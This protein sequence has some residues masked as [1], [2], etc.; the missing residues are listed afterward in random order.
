MVVDEGMVSPRRGRSPDLLGGE[1]Q[2]LQLS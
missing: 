2:P 1:R